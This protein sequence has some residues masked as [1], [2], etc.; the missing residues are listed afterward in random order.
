VFK[1]F[2]GPALALALF[3]GRQMVAS[4]ARLA[5]LF[6]AMSRTATI[7]GRGR[8]RGDHPHA[9]YQKHQHQ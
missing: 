9:E 1:S 4:P 8:S 3:G 6:A 2:S 7:I 5:E